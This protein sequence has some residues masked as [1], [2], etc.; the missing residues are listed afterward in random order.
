MIDWLLGRDNQDPQVEVAGRLLPLVIRRNAQA[1][2]MTMRLAPDG[3][4]VRV[5]LPTWGRSAEALA[6]ARTRAGWLAGQL[7]AVPVPVELQ[8]GTDLAYL[9]APLAINHDPARPRKVALGEGE[10]LIGG[11]A[12]SL[13]SR[14]KRW[15]EGEA[16]RLMAEDLSYYCLRAGQP[17]QRLMLTSAKRRWGSCARDGTIRINWRL[18]MAPSFV[19]RSVV[20]HEVAHLVHFDHSPAFHDF[21]DEIFEGDLRGANRWLKREGKNLYLPMG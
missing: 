1:R 2:R 15:L 18:V 14:I 9:G 3:S 11:P 7:A 21:L 13:Q 12:G 8:N 17:Q 4:E 6:F 16:R 19:R 10:L 5:T 20:A